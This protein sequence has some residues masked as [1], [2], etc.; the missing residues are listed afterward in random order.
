MLFVNEQQYAKYIQTALSN[1]GRQTLLNGSSGKLG[2][3]VIA[4]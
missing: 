2:N 1:L 3:Y 4:I